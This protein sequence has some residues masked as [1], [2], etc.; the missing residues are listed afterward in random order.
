MQVKFRCL[1]PVNDFGVNNE[2]L[3]LCGW[4]LPVQI[5]HCFSLIDPRVISEVIEKYA[6]LPGPA[7]HQFTLLNILLKGGSADAWDMWYLLQD[8]DW[9]LRADEE[10]SFEDLMNLDEMDARLENLHL[11][12]LNL[13]VLKSVLLEAS[14]SDWLSVA[15][16]T[17]VDFKFWFVSLKCSTNNDAAWHDIHRDEISNIV[18]FAVDVIY[19][20]YTTY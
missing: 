6:G 8:L 19:N 16:S 17:M 13:E 5:F 18:S 15:W 3:P 11:V 20:T 2:D 9:Q 7:D 4:K 1:S 10:P 14:T 12:R